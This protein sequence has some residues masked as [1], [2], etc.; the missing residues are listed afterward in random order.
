MSGGRELKVIF[1]GHFQTSPPELGNDL[2]LPCDKFGNDPM[3]YAKVNSMLVDKLKDV[4]GRNN[5]FADMN[6]VKLQK[7][8]RGVVRIKG[9][10]PDRY[11][12]SIQKVA[13]KF[14]C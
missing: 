3:F 12:V 9:K 13:C 5:F 11:A 1:F 2:Y 8:A 7:V 10:V 6:M 4:L 14:F